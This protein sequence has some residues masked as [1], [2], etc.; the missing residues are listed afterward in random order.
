MWELCGLDA[1]TKQQHHAMLSETL[2]YAG[3]ARDGRQCSTG[4]D[5]EQ[6]AYWPEK[7]EE[8]GHRDGFL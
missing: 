2:G 1:W 6:N 7:R 5:P 8:I 4:M 3:K